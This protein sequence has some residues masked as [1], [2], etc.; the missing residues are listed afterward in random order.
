MI[1]LKNKI[2]NISFFIKMIEFKILK[3]LSNTRVS[4]VVKIKFR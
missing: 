4:N 1:I 3:K 2:K